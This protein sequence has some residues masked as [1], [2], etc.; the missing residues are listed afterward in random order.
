M[1]SLLLLA[2]ILSM[3]TTTSRAHAADYDPTL[4][5]FWD[6][7]HEP[8]VIEELRLK[9]DQRQSYRS[10]LDELDL[11]FFPLHNKQRQEAIEGL[12]Q[13]V[14]EARTRMKEILEPSQRERLTG[15]LL[16]RVGTSALFDEK[17]APRMRLTDSQRDRIQTIQAE[18]LANVADL[19]QQANDG[20]PRAPLEKRFV[21]LKTSEQKQILALLR[22]EQRTTWKELHGRSFDLKQLGRP[23]FKA[24]ALVNTGEWINSGPISPE[25]LH[26]KVVVVHFYAFGCINCIHNFPAYRD[27][28][29]R[30][31]HSDVV[32]VGIHTPETA[33][34]RKVESV[35][36]EAAEQKLGFPIVV[37]GRNENWDAWGNSIWPSVYLIDK[38]GYLRHWWHGELNWQ[39]ATGEASMRGWIDELL[40]EPAA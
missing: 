29:E 39:G 32:I 7:L 17:V 15:L 22:P 1:R 25:H 24:P 35:R 31:K 28:Q 36:D 14:A 12:S 6:L 13:I 40:A 30:Y 21:D 4:R 11:R 19:E 5:P 2:F 20:K 33:A 3:S 26:G 27:W 37:D 9:P 34:E 16:W 23:I 38:Q 8:A 10:L 18:T